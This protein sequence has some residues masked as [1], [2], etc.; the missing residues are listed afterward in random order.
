MNKIKI[1]LSLFLVSSLCF[2]Q[3]AANENLKYRRSSI[4]T[5]MIDDSNMK[6]GSIVRDNFINSPIPD[7]FDD[8]TLGFRTIPSNEVNKDDP[9]SI[10][11]YLNSKYVAR[12]LVSKWFSRSENGGF[13]MELIKDRGS[14]DA[15]VL[16][17]TVAKA[18]KRGLNMLY[19]SGE[20]L[21]KNTFVLV[22]SF[23]Y[24]DKEEV[25]AKVNTRG[26]AVSS[27]LRLLSYLPG[28][29]SLNKVANVV[30]IAR[31]AAVVVG[32]GFTEKTNAYL[33][34]LKWNDEIAAIFYENYWCTNETASNFHRTLFEQ[35]NLFEL[36]YIG[37]DVS[38]ADVQSTA[39]TNK[40]N[41][42]LVLRTAVKSVDHV[43]SKLQKNHDEFKTKTPLFSGEPLAAKIGLKEGIEKDTKF[44]VLEQRVD[45]EGKTFYKEMGVV[46]VDT[47]YPIWDNRYGAKED[48]PNDYTEKTYFKPVSG[49]PFYEGMLLLQKKF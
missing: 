36:E 42:D 14:Y 28:G 39:F 26:A 31:T 45:D 40:T 48:N 41:E 16:D 23:S 18:S 7:K 10:L 22:N 27:G 43:I 49:G 44:A 8:H 25:A 38:W 17:I 11:Q 1:G 32:K 13:N 34:R 21:I 9:N 12:D 15:S 20:E 5:I 24:T 33:F 2:G 30:D 29:G 46:K 35:S 6:Y 19:D 37:T 3:K 47:G 4:Y